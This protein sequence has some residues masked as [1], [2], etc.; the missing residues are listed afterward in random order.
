MVKIEPVVPSL[1]R[2]RDAVVKTIKLFSGEFGQRAG[3]RSKTDQ[4][5]AGTTKPAIP[6][7]GHR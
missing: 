1:A 7:F 6:G 2:L 3:R 4:E 5:G